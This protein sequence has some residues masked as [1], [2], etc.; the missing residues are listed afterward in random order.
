MPSGVPDAPEGRIARLAATLPAHFAG[1][2]ATVA[3]RIAVL[4][5]Q[6]QSTRSKTRIDSESVYCI[7][8]PALIMVLAA[9][10]ILVIEKLAVPLRKFNG[11]GKIGKRYCLEFAAGD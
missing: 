9:R 6:I 7:L 4:R 8:I 11:V 10:P 1:L 2:A 3:L 5:L